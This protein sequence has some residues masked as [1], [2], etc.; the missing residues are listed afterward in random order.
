MSKECKRDQQTYKD[1]EEFKD[2]ELT[3]CTAFEMAIRSKY[4]KDRIEEEIQAKKQRDIKTKE[5]QLIDRELTLEEMFHV[6]KT[7]EVEPHNPSIFEELGIDEESYQSVQN[8]PFL[9]SLLKTKEWAPSIIFRNGEYCSQRE[10]RLCE[11]E[12]GNLYLINEVDLEGYRITNEVKIFADTV[13]EY[14]ADGSYTRGAL[15]KNSQE[16]RKRLNDNENCH[17]MISNNKINPKFSRP[18]LGISGIYKRKTMLE[19]NLSLPNHENIKY[20]EHIMADLKKDPDLVKSKVELFG[21]RLISATVLK[22]LNVKSSSKQFKLANMFYIYDAYQQ[23]MSQ[24]QIKL[25]LS[26]YNNA[27]VDERIIKNS[28]ELAKKY[29]DKELYKELITG[30]K[31]NH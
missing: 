15:I 21:D 23:G 11:D 29:I 6:N 16:L 12:S 18:E 1:I 3:Q 28:Y 30:V 8:H 25:E 24:S 7:F 10:D 9:Y 31:N 19:L 2:Y 27:N 5:D 17:T 4:F 14:H 26:H 13:D 20:L 22:E